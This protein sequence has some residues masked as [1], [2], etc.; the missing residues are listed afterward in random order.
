MCLGYLS[1]TMCLA[2]FSAGHNLL[3]QSSSVVAQGTVVHP[4]EDIRRVSVGPDTRSRQINRQK[5]AQPERAISMFPCLPQVA[6]D[7]VERD[8]IDREYFS[9]WSFEGGTRNSVFRGLDELKSRKPSVRFGL[10][11]LQPSPEQRVSRVTN[12]QTAGHSRI[13]PLTVAVDDDGD[14][15]GSP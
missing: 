2:Y 8:E 13:E 14:C 15:T 1:L 3:K 7:P 10:V 6:V 4:S 12:E 11:V 5:V 9:W